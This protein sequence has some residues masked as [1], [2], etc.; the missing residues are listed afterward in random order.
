MCATRIEIQSTAHVLGPKTWVTDVR[1][2]S[3]EKQNLSHEDFP[4]LSLTRQSSTSLGVNVR[5]CALCSG[6]SSH[7]H[8]DPSDLNVF[9]GRVPPQLLGLWATLRPGPC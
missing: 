9:R 7:S 8:P 2:L 3:L 1:S 6:E 5:P 4:S